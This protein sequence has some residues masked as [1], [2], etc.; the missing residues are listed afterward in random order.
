MKK[1]CRE[2]VGLRDIV[3]PDVWENS[4]KNVSK[5]MREKS[6]KEFIEGVPVPHGCG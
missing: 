2:G 3:V 6:T 1:R 4:E 5:N